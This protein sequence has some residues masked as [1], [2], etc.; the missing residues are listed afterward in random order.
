MRGGERR[1]GIEERRVL[2][3][4]RQVRH[5]ER[6]EEVGG[7]R[8]SR[9]RRPGLNRRGFFGLMGAALVGAVAQR[10]LPDIPAPEPLEPAAGTSYFFA[11]PGGWQAHSGRIAGA[12]PAHQ[13]I[14]FHPDSFVFAME[15]IELDEFRRSHI[16][17]AAKELARRIDEQALALYNVQNPKIIVEPG[18]G[19]SFE[20]SE[21]FEK[22]IADLQAQKADL[23]RGG[24]R[25]GKATMMLAEDRDLGISIRVINQWA[26]RLDVLYGYAV[27]RP[28]LAC[29]IASDPTMPEDEILVAAGITPEQMGVIKGIR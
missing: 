29:Q 24:Q 21:A 5:E 2:P 11:P 19:A 22:Q 13:S 3:A 4:G 27:L 23:F 25:S 26:P 15:D 9:T 18:R 17:A 20:Y 6:L 8:S 16:D 7:D 10:V 1:E 12:L 28:E 14:A